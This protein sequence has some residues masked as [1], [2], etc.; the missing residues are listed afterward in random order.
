MGQFLTNCI[1]KNANT[2]VLLQRVSV[3]A[4]TG[5]VGTA[6]GWCWC[7]CPLRHIQQT[8]ARH[9]KKCHMQRRV[10]TILNKLPEIHKQQLPPLCTPQV[11]KRDLQEQ[12]DSQQWGWQQGFPRALLRQQVGEDPLHGGRCCFL[13][14]EALGFQFSPDRQLTLRVERKVC[15]KW[16]LQ[17]CVTSLHPQCCSNT[18]G[19][20]HVPTPEELLCFALL[21]AAPTT[22]LLPRGLWDSSFAHTAP[23]QQLCTVR[24]YAPELSHTLT[25]PPKRTQGLRPVHTGCFR[26]FLWNS[27]HVHWLSHKWMVFSLQCLSSPSWRRNLQSQLAPQNPGSWKWNAATE[28]TVKSCSKPV[29]SGITD[30]VPLC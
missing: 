29:I 8:S 30:G 17:R 5:S 7:P 22:C 20:S 12:W 24:N 2:V 6:S 9:F 11:V 18:C 10:Q 25:S 4:V 14:M 13:L 27:H 15:G 26:R 1:S 19:R 3:W 21:W 16:W 23:G 28:N